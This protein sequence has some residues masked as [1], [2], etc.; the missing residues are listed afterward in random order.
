MITTLYRK[1]FS[2][3]AMFWQ[4]NAL[5]LPA[6]IATLQQAMRIRGCKHK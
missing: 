4:Y 1:I 2:I 3:T 6:E 5:S